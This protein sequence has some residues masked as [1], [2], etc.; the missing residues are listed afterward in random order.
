[1]GEFLF[2]LLFLGGVSC[3]GFYYII[4]MGFLL[5]GWELEIEQEIEEDLLGENEALKKQLRIMGEV[6]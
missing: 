6:I 5:A 1:M 2:I 3:W 4:K